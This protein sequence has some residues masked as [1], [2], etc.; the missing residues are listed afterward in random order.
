MNHS[1]IDWAYILSMIKE[2][3][4]LGIYTRQVPSL[5]QL[6]YIKLVL[7]TL[8]YL[9]ESTLLRELIFKEVVMVKGIRQ[10]L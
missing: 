2:N 8:T 9:T 1:C 7:H 4:D 3:K 6:Y 10:H 5:F